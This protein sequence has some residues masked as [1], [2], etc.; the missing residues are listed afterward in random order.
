VSRVV[1]ESRV[2]MSCTVSLYHVA[3]LGNARQR[4]A[5]HG[6]AW[7]HTATHGNAQQRLSTHGNARQCTATHSNA[8]QR[9]ATH[10]NTLQR[11]CTQSRTVFLSRVFYHVGGSHP[12]NETKQESLLLNTVYDTH[13]THMS[14][15]EGPCLIEQTCDVGL[16]S[17]RHP[18]EFT[19]GTLASIALFVVPSS[20]MR[21]RE[22]NK[23]L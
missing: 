6:N 15:S 12:K 11:I 10:C 1:S 13:V 5:M 16:H 18:M 20:D 3:T 9:T 4:T 19:A 2:L 14:E 21:N 17:R 8:L 22:K 7:Q 23:L